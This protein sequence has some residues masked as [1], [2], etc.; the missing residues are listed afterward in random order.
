MSDWEIDE[1]PAQVSKSS[2]EWEIAPE[3]T[4]PTFG[5]A[6]AQA[7]SKI[8]EDVTG[9]GMNLLKNIPG[10]Y[11]S[12][13]TEVPGIV[14]AF[15]NNPRHAL[16]QIAAG[17]P[18]LGQKTFNA[19]HD[20]INYLSQ[21]LNL[22]PENANRMVQMGRMPEDTQGMINQ[23]FGTPDQPGES[24]LRGG[25]RNAINIAGLKGVGSLANP[26]RYTSGGIAKNVLGEEARQV[27]GH[28]KRYN[29]IWKQA[30]KSGFNNVPYDQ[31]LV[32]PHAS[33]IE[34]FYPEKSTLAVNNFIDHPTLQNA[35]KAQSDL[36]N[37]RRSI[38]EKAK[39]TPLLE[40]EKILHKALFESEKNIEQNMFKDAGGN[41]NN[42]LQ[43][44]YK[45]LTNSYRKNV[46]PYKY[47]PDIQ[48]YKAEEITSPELVNALSRGEFARKKGWRHPAIKIN[49]SLPTLGTLGT[50]GVGAYLG[51]E[52][53]GSGN[54]DQY[55]NQKQ[56][57]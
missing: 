37:L 27:A 24:L 46:V 18:E 21:R 43:D 6:L 32:I 25:M 16:S 40:S 54:Q 8:Y 30:D 34:K 3:M 4:S 2:P 49:R 48:S 47:N 51:K 42:S 20:L 9:A 28:S 56:Q 41:I 14:S 35:Q 13:K 5:E 11:Q 17:I 15:R 44:K 12:A 39:K 10:Y 1:S 53:L 22:V 36:G 45:K 38:E 55:P 29:K 52:L 19:P 23:T 33:F 50:F 26:L 7:P 31:D 57:Y